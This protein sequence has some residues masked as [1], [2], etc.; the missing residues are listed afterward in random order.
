M[1]KKISE[2]LT[3]GEYIYVYIHR[4]TDIYTCKNSHLCLTSNTATDKM[5]D[6]ETR[7]QLSDVTWVTPRHGH[8]RTESLPVKR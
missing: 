3:I 7:K 8:N 2:L 1:Y 6:A 4:T 5:T